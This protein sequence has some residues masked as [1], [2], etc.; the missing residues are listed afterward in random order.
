MSPT[1]ASIT[2]GQ[3]L[4]MT[5]GIPIQ[6]GGGRFDAEEKD[7]VGT[8]LR[9]GA[10]NEPGTITE[11][12][13][14][15]AHLVAAVLAEATGQS[16]LDYP[17]EAVWAARIDTEPA[18]TG[19][20][21]SYDTSKDYTAAGFAWPTD[22]E[23]INL[24]CCMV[25]LTADDMVK[26][27]ELYRNGGA[28]QGKQIVPEDWVKASTTIDPAEPNPIPVM[29]S[30]L[31]YP[32]PVLH[33]PDR[34]A[35][36]IR[37]RRGFRRNRGRARPKDGRRDLWTHDRNWDAGHSRPRLLGGDRLR[38]DCATHRRLITRLQSNCQI[39]RS[40]TAISPPLLGY[41]FTPKADFCPAPGRRARLRPCKQVLGTT[42]GAG[43]GLSAGLSCH[44]SPPSAQTQRHQPSA[45]AHSR[46][47]PWKHRLA[48]L[49]SRLS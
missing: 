24:G 25:K 14:A 1:V 17:R 27:G 39:N 9:H 2:L 19:V 15:G 23:G 20:E 22:R 6:V 31:D 16:V 18:D 46:K 7:S 11:F 43:A 35:S 47:T 38:G 34:G 33:H 36:R 4:N 40:D 3:L 44:R 8:V 26:I 49:E 29:T 37:R 42:A 32:K 13:D 21:Y 28:W 48:D 30:G 12:S 5:S 41:R 45:P 10:V